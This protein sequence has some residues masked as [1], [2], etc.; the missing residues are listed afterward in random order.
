[1]IQI[2]HREV[3]MMTLQDG[4]SALASSPQLELVYKECSSSISCTVRQSMNRESESPLTTG[5]RS[6]NW[7]G[8]QGIRHIVVNYSLRAAGLFIIVYC[9]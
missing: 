7:E 4:N 3:S 8:S 5:R 6:H 1:M 2:N 9:A